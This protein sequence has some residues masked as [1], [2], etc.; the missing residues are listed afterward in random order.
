[1]PICWTPRSTQRVPCAHQSLR[2]S[3]NGWIAQPRPK[4]DLNFFA[5]D[6][7][8]WNCQLRHPTGCIRRTFK[9][10]EPCH[11]RAKLIYKDN[12]FKEEA[13]KITSKKD[14]VLLAQL[15]SGLCKILKAYANLLD[16][17]VD[18]TC[19][20]CTPEPQTLEHWL[21]CPATAKD[22]FEFFCT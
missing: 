10:P 2:L 11:H 19:P 5:H 3:N 20:L 14:S 15:R 6:K 8:A 21:D 13:K 1:M 12:N 7:P 18:P 16:P 17:T 22:R 4:I 9:D